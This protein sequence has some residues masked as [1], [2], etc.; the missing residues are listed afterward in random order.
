MYIRVESISSG[1]VALWTEE[2]HKIMQIY[3]KDVH[4]LFRTSSWS[5]L[6]VS[7]IKCAVIGGDTQSVIFP[8]LCVILTVVFA[9]VTF[10]R[11]LALEWCAPLSNGTYS[12]GPWPFAASRNSVASRGSARAIKR[13]ST[14]HS[15]RLF[16][17][18]RRLCI[19]I[20]QTGVGCVEKSQR[21]LVY[22]GERDGY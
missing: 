18:R 15:L 13:E 21:L 19:A 14:R 9:M 3:R 6:A 1:P 10:R 5:Q 11:Y 12:L 4:E 17:R 7:G 20:A 16:R 22:W 2:A 8:V